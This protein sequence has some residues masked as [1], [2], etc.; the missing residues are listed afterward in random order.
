MD[1][2][3]EKALDEPVDLSHRFDVTSQRLERDDV[4][5]LSPVSFSG[6]LRK[7]D[8]G[9][10]LD[11][12][13]SF[14]GTTT[15]ARCLK[16]VS[17]RRSGPVSWVFAPSHEK[18]AVG[19]DEEVELSARDLDIVWYDDFVVPFDPLIDEQVLLELPMKALCRDDCRGLCPMCGSDRNVAACSCV[20][21]TDDRWSALKALRP[22]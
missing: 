2:D 3:L 20:E 14:D 17:F 1:L 22:R 7:A 10:V 19:E 12:Q 16:P 4:L 5:S 18:N 13:L 9:F 6:H 11:G 15:C 21:P 8:T